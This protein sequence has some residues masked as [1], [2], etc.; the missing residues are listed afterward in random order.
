MDFY[1]QN[2]TSNKTY[3]LELYD[4]KIQYSQ[5]E[6]TDF[7]SLHGIRPHS[8]DKRFGRNHQELG[9]GSVEECQ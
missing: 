8:K 9:G 6:R 2:L 5:I 7:N 4:R 1:L 3:I